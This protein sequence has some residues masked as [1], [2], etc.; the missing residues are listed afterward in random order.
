M[1]PDSHCVEVRV[2][3]FSPTDDLLSDNSVSCRLRTGT[4]TADSHPLKALRTAGGVL[5]RAHSRLMVP[6]CVE[7]FAQISRERPLVETCSR[8]E[9]NGFVVHARKSAAFADGVLDSVSV[10]HGNLAFSALPQGG[11]RG[12]HDAEDVVL[13]LPASVMRYTARGGQTVHICAYTVPIKTFGQELRVHVSNF[14]KRG[15]V[16]TDVL[17]AGYDH[18]RLYRMA[19]TR[20]VPHRDFR[21]RSM[22]KHRMCIAEVG[23]HGS[24]GGQGCEMRCEGGISSWTS[25]LELGEADVYFKTVYV[26]SS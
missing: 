21:L 25:K 2:R 17:D 24:V 1:G 15:G 14:V 13:A 19:Q 23:L 7:A 16:W 6:D 8:L 5:V 4:L 9:A 26:R 11:W 12:A 20:T 3:V 22:H 18:G 10:H